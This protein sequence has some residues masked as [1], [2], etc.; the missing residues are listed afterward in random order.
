MDL[1]HL[2]KEQRALV[3]ELLREECEVFSKNDS[4][5]GDIKEFQM[6]LRMKMI[7]LN[8]MSR[9]LL[10]QDFQLVSF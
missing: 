5:I 3:E 1:S 8:Q 6:I 4:D 10:E 9:Q 2:N 7:N